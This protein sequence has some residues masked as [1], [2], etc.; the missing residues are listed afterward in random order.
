M[1]TLFVVEKECKGK[2]IVP[3]VRKPTIFFP[4]FATNTFYKILISYA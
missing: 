4:S 2:K 3:E 1:D